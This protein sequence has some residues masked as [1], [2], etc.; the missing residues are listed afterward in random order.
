M[1]RAGGRNKSLKED[2]LRINLR[3]MATSSTTLMSLSRKFF[4]TVH[5]F[6]SFF[7]VSAERGT[8][9]LKMLEESNRKIFLI[10]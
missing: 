8:M 6:V 9:W 2:G 10:L 7:M 5:K 4:P 1:A 3:R